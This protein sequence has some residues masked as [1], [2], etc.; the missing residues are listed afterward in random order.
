MKCAPPHATGTNIEG[1]H[2]NDHAETMAH[3]TSQDVGNVVLF[4]HINLEVRQQQIVPKPSFEVTLPFLVL[5]A[6]A[7]AL[8]NITL[9][10][11]EPQPAKLCLCIQYNML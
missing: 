6:V 2:A 8:S 3:D 5:L 1:S 10:F 9:P 7:V 11:V 4:E